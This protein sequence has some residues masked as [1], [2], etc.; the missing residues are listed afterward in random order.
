MS[1][2]DPSGRPPFPI[3]FEDRQVLV[4]NKPA[5]V[6]SQGDA[7]SDPCVLDLMKAYIK[8]REGKPG[9]VFLSVVHRLDRPVSGALILAR[10][11]KAAA[12][13]LVAFQKDQIRKTY[14]AVVEG[15]VQFSSVTRRSLLQKDSQ[16]NTVHE[17]PL[18]DQDKHPEARTAVTQ[19][20]LVQGGPDLSLMQLKPLTGRSHQLRVHCQALGHPILGDL[21]YS[22]KRGLGPRILLHAWR[23]S[24]P[25]P[26]SNETQELQAPVPP[27]WQTAL[28]QDHPL[29]KALQ[30]L[31]S[32]SEPRTK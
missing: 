25:H 31:D 20:D 8:Q 3:L 30:G 17:F 24:F 1:Q 7:S 14:L 29:S 22:S 16:R 13:L 23:I 6:P 12:R 19:M 28:G 4:V 15:Q 5:G 21:R 18:E 10:T 11:S 26:I 2:A 32:Q 9:A 27:E